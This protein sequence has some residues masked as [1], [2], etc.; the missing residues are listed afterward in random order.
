L[1]LFSFIQRPDISDLL[2]LSSDLNAIKK[3]PS[4]KEL[5]SYHKS[6]SVTEQWPAQLTSNKKL[7]LGIIALNFEKSK[8]LYNKIQLNF[9]NL[10]YKVILLIN[11]ES[12]SLI[13][14]QMQMLH[15][16]ER[17]I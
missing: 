1:S 5:F 13:M 6:R 10:Y 7:Y 9:G 8:I 14:V 12:I 4:F 3:K 11:Y 16:I 2:I 17:N 15:N